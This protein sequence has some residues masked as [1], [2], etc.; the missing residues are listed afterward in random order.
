M[1]KRK[2]LIVVLLLTLL[3]LSAFSAKMTITWWINPWRIAPPGFPSDKAPSSE[4]YPKWASE[5]F[6]RLHPEVEVKYVVVGNQ[7]YSQKMAAAIATR[8]QPD[9]FKGPVWDSR[10]A[11]NGL[12]EPID[13]YLSEEDWKDFYQVVLDEGLIDGKRY[14]WPW[15]FGT[16]GMGTSMLLYT[17][18][19]DKAEIDWRKIV[20]EGWTMEEFVEICKKLTWDT[21]GNGEIDHYAIS[22]GAKDLHNIINFLYAFGGRLSDEGETTVTLNTPEAAAGLQFVLDL[23]NKYKVAPKGVEALGVY[24]VIGNFH[25]HRT[26]IGFGGPYEIGRITRYILA[27]TLKEMF[28]PV[29]APF[30]HVEGKDP[31]AHTSGSGFIIFKQNDQA[32][33]EMVFEFVKFLTNQQNLALLETLQYLTARESVNQKL[34]VNDPYMNKQ[35]KTYG[36]IMDKY[37]MS[38]FG[39]QEFPWSQMEKFIISAFEATF[40]GS[41]TPQK[42][43]DEFVTEADKILKKAK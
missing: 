21:D 10:W 14:I 33:R 23:V 25:S 9:F 29:L 18:D 43:L 4:D 1:E 5:E 19:F 31:V 13:S 12:L 30:P 37:G 2:I 27:G 26:S 24:D 39:S 6:M 8:T 36:A 40:A 11:Q 41:K 22:F 32:K 16:N 17:P 42:A 34:Y 15:N 3:S 7:E 35:V 38:F 28:Y 20:Q